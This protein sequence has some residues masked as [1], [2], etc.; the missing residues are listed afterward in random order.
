VVGVDFADGG[1]EAVVER[2][3]ADVFWIAGLVERV[4]AGYPGVVLVA[5]GD[6]LPQPDCAVLVVLGGVSMYCGSVD[7]SGVSCADSCGQLQ[8]VSK[9]F[10]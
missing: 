10:H 8:G 6:L 7:K 1:L 9:R 3:K 2:R 5:S 4:V